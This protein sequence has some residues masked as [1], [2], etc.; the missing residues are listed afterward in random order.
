MRI[1]SRFDGVSDQAGEKKRVE[2]ITTRE[3]TKINVLF[4]YRKIVVA[5]RGN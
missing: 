3:S 2:K 1:T 5:S 4:N